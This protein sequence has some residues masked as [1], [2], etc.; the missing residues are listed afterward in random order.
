[1]FGFL[2]VRELFAS[3]RSPILVSASES[4][5]EAQI[6]MDNEAQWIH[7]KRDPSLL[8]WRDVE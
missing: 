7:K 4:P 2:Q 1:M 5:R 3:A 8:N 6:R